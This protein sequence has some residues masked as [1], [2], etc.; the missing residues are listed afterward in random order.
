MKKILLLLFIAQ[1]TFAQKEGYWDKERSTTKE[2]VLT[3]GK[4]ILIKT[5]ELPFGT[6]EFLYRITL[7]DEGQKLTSNLASVLKSIPDPT[8][9]SQ[10]TAGLIHLTSAISGDDKCTYAIFQEAISANQFLKEGTTAKACFDQKE[11]INKE[12]RMLTSASL[13]L[14]NL[15]N[16]WFGFESQNWVMNQKIVLELVPWVDYKASRGWDKSTK[17]EL[18][19]LANKQAV[20]QKLNQKNLFSSVFIEKMTK[21]Y[22]YREFSDLL[23]VE[24]NYAI[25]TITEESLRATGEIKAYYDIIRDKSYAA[26]K[27][28][29]IE[30][31][32]TIITIEMLAKGRATYIDYGMLGD[33]YL[34][35]K[36]FTKAED[37][38]VKGVKLNPSEIH[39]QLNLAHV[40]LFTDR[41]SEAKA[42]HKQYAQEN[43]SSG[44]SW[45]EQAT[46]DFKAFEKYDLPTNNFKKILRI[47]D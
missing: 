12:A 18:L 22:S 47:L 1:I 30:E 16:L 24:K 35:S 13:C 44:K 17:E 6:T 42:I 15:P 10:G 7:L 46:S 32:I 34:F 25:D 33:Y 19:L 27:K 31:A 5:E 26:F 39:F 41:I 3:A 36:Q 43:L 45:K 9:I 20:I 38:Y 40:Y 28:G 8:G 14:T 4:R 21:K 29:E 2:V 37:V 23:Q 11:K